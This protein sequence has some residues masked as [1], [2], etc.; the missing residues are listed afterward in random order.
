MDKK[1]IIRKMIFGLLVDAVT[2]NYV[3]NIAD[4][5]IDDVVNDVDECADPVEW[6]EDDVRLAVGRAFMS[7]LNLEY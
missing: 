7:K 4:A 1:D 5:I 6:N 3:N 2:D